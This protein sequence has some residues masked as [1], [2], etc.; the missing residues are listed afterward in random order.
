MNLYRLIIINSPDNLERGVWA[1]EMTQVNNC[2]FFRNPSKDDKLVAAYPSRITIIT[3]VETKE[4]HEAAQKRK[5]SAIAEITRK[6][7]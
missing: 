7:W 4:D 6:K 5:E 3:S 1:E 2:Y